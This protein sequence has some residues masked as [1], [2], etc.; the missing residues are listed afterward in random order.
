M[1]NIN[2][3]ISNPLS[4]RF[5]IVKTWYGKTPFKNK[6]WEVQINKTNDII[7][8]AVDWTIRKD[9]AGLN[10]SFGLLGFDIIFVFYDQRHWDYVTKKMR[11]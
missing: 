5:I 9:H 11:F 6:F 2:F 7:K 10:V 8:I 1:I 3:S 4:R